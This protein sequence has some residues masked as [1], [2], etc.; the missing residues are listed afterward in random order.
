MCVSLLLCFQLGGAETESDPPPCSPPPTAPAFGSELSWGQQSTFTFLLHVGAFPLVCKTPPALVPPP[1]W[2][3]TELGS[4]TSPRAGRWG[5]FG[6]EFAGHRIPQGQG[7]PCTP[8]CSSWRCSRPARKPSPPCPRLM[9]GCIPPYP[10]HSQP[11]C[12]CSLHRVF[13]KTSP[14][15]KVSP[16]T[17][18]RDRAGP[19]TVQAVLGLLRCG[20]RA[21]AGF[22]FPF[23]LA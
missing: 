21:P 18:T 15:S 4:G 2:S 14:N 19:P 20:S 6:S 23:K 8:W 3:H 12:L 9:N 11:I 22:P 5:G 13:K 10:G 1:Q 17:E 7:S 16:C